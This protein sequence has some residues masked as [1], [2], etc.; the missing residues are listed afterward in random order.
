MLVLPSGF[1]FANKEE[2]G[3]VG[4]IGCPGGRDD[5][6]SSVGRLDGAKNDVVRVYVFGVCEGRE[7]SD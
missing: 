5:I 3:G 1:Q 2:P 4:S 7:E 6:A